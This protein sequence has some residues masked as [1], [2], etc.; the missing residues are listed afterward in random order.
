MI[1][2]IVLAII[3]FFLFVGAF[4]IAGKVLDELLKTED[5]WK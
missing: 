4:Y 1:V 5:P 2:E 3:V